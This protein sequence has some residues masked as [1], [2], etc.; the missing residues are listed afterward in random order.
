[1][2]R[3]KDRYQQEIIPAMMERFQYKNVM[4]VPKIGRAH[5]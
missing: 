4:E 5:V 3:L 2:A 1:M